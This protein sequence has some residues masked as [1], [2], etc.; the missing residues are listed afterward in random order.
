M[1]EDDKD[2]WKEIILRTTETSIRA[3]E[4]HLDQA[5]KHFEDLT[6]AHRK[7]LEIDKQGELN[8]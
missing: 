4:H 8:V 2:L 7:V 6:A 3:I 1:S 5:N